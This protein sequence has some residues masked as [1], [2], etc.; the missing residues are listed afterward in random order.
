MWTGFCGE[1]IRSRNRNLLIAIVLLAAAPG[2]FLGCFHRYFA[3]FFRGSQNI[4]IRDVTA[5]SAA[6][7]ADRF[8]RIKPDRW[9][10]TGID[11]MGTRDKYDT[12]VRYE[13]TY[14]LAS[15]DG[16]S[17][18]IY[19]GR[20]PATGEHTTES[21]EGVLVPLSARA[22]LRSRFG[23]IDAFDPKRY[24]PVFLDT[25][26]YRRFGRIGLIVSACF[27]LP[28]LWMLC[29]YLWRVASPAHHPFAR[30]L[31]SY[32]PLASLLRQL[33]AEM[34]SAHATV[35]SGSHRAEVSRHWLIAVDRFSATPMPLENILWFYDRK[36]SRS[37][38]CAVAHDGS[39][40]ILEVASLSQAG[41][42]AVTQAIAANDTVARAIRGYDPRLSALWRSMPDK[43]HFPR[44][45]LALMIPAPISGNPHR[46]ALPPPPVVA[47][48]PW[49][50]AIAI[51][52]M[53]VAFF[54][55]TRLAGALLIHFLNSL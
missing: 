45:A 16:G 37:A 46:M 35:G 53:M 3:G 11:Q 25:D 14:M 40:R 27:L 22:V 41:A 47:R 12:K 23:S 34:R 1:L 26:H 32:G 20:R 31:A 17:M 48:K 55:V 28:A 21:F 8:V 10:P 13:G 38:H 7:A 52:A 39:G 44:A 19:V 54:V 36:I 5:M 24:G 18:L 43:S 30:R 2:I 9:V 49:V 50:A 15:G 33:D 4:N 6:T 29:L 51:A 42:A